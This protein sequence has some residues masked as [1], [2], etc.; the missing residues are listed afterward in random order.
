LADPNG[1]LRSISSAA[2]GFSSVPRTKADEIEDYYSRCFAD[3][4][5]NITFIGFSG[6]GQMAYSTAQALTSRIFVDNLVLLGGAFRAH[7]GIGNIGHI[8][9]LVGIND[10]DYTGKGGE[11]LLGWDS[12]NRGYRRVSDYRFGTVY[13][14]DSARDIYQNGATRCTLYGPQYVH[15]LDGDYFEDR[16]SVTYGEVTLDL[17]FNGASCSG[18][19][20]GFH[21]PGNDRSRLDFLVNFLIQYVGVGRQK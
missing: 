13:I 8:W 16:T 12:Y 2:Y 21:M 19:G 14:R 1:N 5:Y 18:G 6:G 10:T 9:D 20:T 11:R 17:P 15:Y 4:E 7:S 3:D